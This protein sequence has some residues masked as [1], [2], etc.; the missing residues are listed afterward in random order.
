M[1]IVYRKEIYDRR[2][3]PRQK[4]SGYIF[5]ATKNSF[6]EAK[7][8]NY[9]NQGLFV[10]ADVP[11]PVGEIIEVALPYS[12]EKDGKY[13]AKIIRRTSIGNG[14]KLLQPSNVDQIYREKILK[15]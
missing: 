4:Y 7:L 2:K 8:K 15:W 12:S 9:S 6:Y 3:E 11:L 10:E 13:L 1:N 14:V 5:F